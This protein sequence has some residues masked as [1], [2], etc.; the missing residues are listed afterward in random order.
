MCLIYYDASKKKKNLLTKRSHPKKYQRTVN[1]VDRIHA[2]F[3]MIDFDAT[4]TIDRDELLEA[5]GADKSNY[6]KEAFRVFDRNH[7]GNL[8]FVE[9]LVATTKVCATRPLVQL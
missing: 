1:Q 5:I 8:D 6:A 3:N 4:R 2:S 9:F 7:D